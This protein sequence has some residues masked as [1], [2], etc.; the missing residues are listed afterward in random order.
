LDTL[1]FS[2]SGVYRLQQLANQV[3]N[4]TGIRHKLSDPSDVVSLL[5]K[6]SRSN[7][8]VIQTYYNAFTNELD[9]EQMQSLRLHITDTHTAH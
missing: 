4:V 5:Q 6:C 2:Q 9:A 8:Q 1:I 3:R 7:N